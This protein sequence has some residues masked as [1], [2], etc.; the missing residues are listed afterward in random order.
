MKF[1][2]SDIGNWIS[3]GVNGVVGPPV[4]VM[5][6]VTDEITNVIDGSDS[7]EELAAREQVR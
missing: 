4:A 7:E 1:F 5:G 2:K 6:K 3:A